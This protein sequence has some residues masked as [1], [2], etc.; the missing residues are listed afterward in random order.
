LR[1]L[2]TLLLALVLSGTGCVDA[3]ETT[4][5][6]WFEAVATS[7]DEWAVRSDVGGVYG[8]VPHLEMAIG[9]T[10]W[11]Q[12]P[13]HPVGCGMSD[14]WVLEQPGRTETSLKFSFMEKPLLAPGIY[15]VITSIASLEAP[16]SEHTNHTVVRYFYL[17]GLS[18][19]GTRSSARLLED[20]TTKQQC[21]ESWRAGYAAFLQKAHPDVLREIMPVWLA[22]SML[23]DE[24][25]WWLVRFRREIATEVWAEAS[26]EERLAME[27]IDPELPA[28]GDKLWQSETSA[29]DGRSFYVATYYPQRSL[30][31]LE[32]N[33]SKPP[34]VGQCHQFYGQMDTLLATKVEF[35]EL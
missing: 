32:Q 10:S 19:S 13:G 30:S 20:P 11:V 5:P 17:S 34:S 23:T 3:F 31:F 16:D 24:E 6:V 22:G 9:A 18:E 1:K 33:V 12:A 15:R 21:E 27:R 28:D 26:E 4:S 35:R 2:H 29:S 14:S 8:D 7:P 25:K